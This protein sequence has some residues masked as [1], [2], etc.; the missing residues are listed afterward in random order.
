MILSLQNQVYLFFVTI[1][2]GF[3][4]GLIYDFFRIL[5]KVFT[6]SNTLVYFEDILFWLFS[7]FIAFFILLHKNN[8]E[9]RFY[10]LIGIVLGLIFYFAIISTFVLKISLT[11][12]EQL[13]KP[14]AFLYK[15]LKPHFKKATILKNKAIN[16]EKI[17]LQKV[18][19]YGKIKCNDFKT[20]IKIIKNKI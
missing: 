10:L 18:N 20:T 16:K 5:R 11:I 3:I 6:H 17:V 7:T 9:F 19:R 2:I 14:I 15:F 13:L 12:I 8:L 1:L 4:I